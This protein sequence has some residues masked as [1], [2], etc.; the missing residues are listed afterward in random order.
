VDTRLRKASGE[1][2]DGTIIAAAGLVRMDLAHVITEY[3]SPDEFVPPPGQGA[4]AVEIRVGDDRM[5]ELV[6]VADDGRTAAAVAAERSFLEALG[7]G[8]QVPVGAYAEADGTDGNTLRLTVFMGAPDG[9]AAYRASVVG[10]AS[11]T[12]DLAAAAWERLRERG[13]AELLT[14]EDRN[15]G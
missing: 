14:T 12:V 7:G 15:D 5:A 4:M 13:A 6:G 3:L 1:E 9:S 10:A 2:C 11:D 8:C